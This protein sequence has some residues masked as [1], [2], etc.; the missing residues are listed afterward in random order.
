[1]G[2][3]GL[4]LAGGIMGG[5]PGALVGGAAS[6][7]F[8]YALDRNI[9]RAALFSAGSTLLA[10]GIPAHPWT[11]LEVAGFLALTA[12]LGAGLTWGGKFE[13]WLEPR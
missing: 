5:L 2:W 11:A 9:N 6:L 8:N 4:P 7:G 3:L 1:V 10:A 12:A 13:D